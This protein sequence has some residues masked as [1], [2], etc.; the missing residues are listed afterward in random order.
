MM[1]IL[2]VLDLL[3]GTVVRGIA[4]QRH[5]YR[6][7]RSVLT[8][9]S[10]PLAVARAFRD[11]L[12]LSTLY[13]ADLDAILHRR[14]NFACYRELVA[15]G[16]E[17]LV[18]AGL[19]GLDDAAAVLGCGAQ[20]VIAGLETSPDPALLAS[21]CAS[22]GAERVVFSLDLKAGD[23]LAD[24]AGWGGRAPLELAACAVAQ[25]IRRMIVLDLAQVGVGAGVETMTLCRSIRQ[26]WPE[27]ELITGG[28]VRGRSDLEELARLGLAGALVASA[29]HD[30][31]IGRDDLVGFEI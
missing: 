1:Q 26:Q 13:L 10:R 4:G 11:Q 20:Q 21:L 5:H 27:I 25:G 8:P 2:P 6:P 31:R 23:P 22:F 17:L 28:G 18:D 3:E 29:L 30:G 16:F 12:G 9:D 24:A 14:P 15:E 7:V 19:R